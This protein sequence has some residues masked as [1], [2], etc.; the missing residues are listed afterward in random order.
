[1]LLPAVSNEQDD[2]ARV[3]ALLRRS[4]RVTSFVVFPMLMG[5][6]LVAEP[7]VGVLMTDKWLGCVP[8]MRIYCLIC[9]MNVGMIPR[10]QAL[11]GIGRSDVF[12]YEHMAARV[13][14]FVLLFAVYKIS[15]MAIAISGI[16]SGIVLLLTVMYTS[17]RFNG[18]A[19]RDQIRDVIPS[20]AGCLVMAVCVYPISLLNLSNFAML[21]AQ[22]LVGVAAYVIYGFVFKLEEV[23]IMMNFVSR[24]LKKK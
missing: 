9:A 23:Q 7:L 3:V 20:V 4:V 11:N 13:M 21:A 14:G 5:L 12:M 18:Y 6:A 2:D 22:I 10:H 17:K 1:M 15:V 19:Y 8:Y 16:A 24:F